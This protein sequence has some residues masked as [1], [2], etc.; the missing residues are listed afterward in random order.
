MRN[1]LKSGLT[2]VAAAIIMSGIALA[3]EPRERHGLSLMGDLKY[4][5]DFKHFD[6]VNPDAPK[7]GKLRLSAIDTFDSL[8]P[9]ILKGNASGLVSYIYESLMQSSRDEPSSEYGL[10]AES[11]SHPDDFSSVTYTLRAKA[12]WHDGKPVTP[13]DVIFSFNSLKKA[14]PRYAYYYA[15]ITSAEKVGDR[16]VKFTFNQKGNRELP[17]ITGQI[18]VLPK[19]YWEGTDAQGKKRDFFSS[20]LEPPLGSGPYRVKEVKPGRSLTVERVEDYWGKDVPVTVGKFNF[21]EIQLEYFRDSVV[22]LEAFK[23]DQYDVRPENSAKFWATSY[24]FKAVKNGNVILDV[25]KS[26]NA[27][28]MQSFVFNT[29]RERFADPRV[30]QAFNYAF[31]FEWAN[32]TLFFGQYSRVNSYFANSELASS[33][34]PQ[35]LELEILEP[36]RDQLPKEVFTTEYKNPIGGDQA[37]ARRNLREAR[38]LLKEAGWV[39]K[40]AK[41][42]NAKSGEE[43][44]IEFLLVSP[45]FERIVLPYVQSL[46]RLGIHAT[47]RTIDPSQYQNRLR[48]F[49]F[50]SIVNSWG[51]SL[52]PGNEQRDYWGSKSADR[53]GSQNFIGIKNPAVD[54]LIEKIIFAKDR[55]ELVAATR[56][57]DRVLLWNHYVVPQWYFSGLRIARWN[58][59]GMPERQPEFGYGYPNT[60]W[61][62]EQKAAA[63]K[64]K[65]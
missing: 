3:E 60:W 57:L 55:E 16:K 47:V 64:G 10:L 31:N 28:P 4:A 11:V 59:F 40:G 50:D 45:L 22:A 12:R 35:G 34:L 54:T 58:R 23:A 62:D 42:V 24:D 13:E 17:L 36:L 32:K 27:E 9:F 43:M 46:K 65:G 21:D 49:D 2:G 14:H 5:P 63:I 18:T 41:L 39:V 15:N 52:S 33:G 25:L 53:V 61:Y 1:L 29:R 44:K 8:H 19:H 7:G 56:A 26:R 37:T 20:T 38:K 48:D 6:Y 30:R 51:Q